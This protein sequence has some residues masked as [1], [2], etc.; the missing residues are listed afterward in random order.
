MSR[1]SGPDLLQQIKRIIASYPDA[2]A[3]LEEYHWI[4]VPRTWEHLTVPTE[5]L[6]GVIIEPRHEDRHGGA[7]FRVGWNEAER[8]A[9]LWML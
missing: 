7:G 5:D 6:L 3:D 2:P 1:R 9:A 4:T 8:V